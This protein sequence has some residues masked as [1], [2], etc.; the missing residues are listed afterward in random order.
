MRKL[1][2]ILLL[3]LHVALDVVYVLVCMLMMRKSCVV[4][5]HNA[6]LRNPVETNEGHSSELHCA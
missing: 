3:N 5:T 4:G 2:L 6:I 1:A